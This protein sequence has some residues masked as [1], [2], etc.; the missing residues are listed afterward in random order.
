MFDMEKKTFLAV[1]RSGGGTLLLPEPA[2]VKEDPKI[3][4]Y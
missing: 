2:N 4:L 1:L 3:L